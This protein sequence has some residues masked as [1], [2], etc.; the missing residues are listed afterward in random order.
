MGNHDRHKPVK[1]WLEVGF[2]KVYDYPIII[3]NI[4]FSHEPVKS[5]YLN[6][7]G[8][9]HSKNCEEPNCINVSVEAINYSP[10]TL[11]E[12]LANKHR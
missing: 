5:E 2:I 10:I 3:N 7:H 1:W 8:H 6:I 9:T 12:C 4:I 11:E